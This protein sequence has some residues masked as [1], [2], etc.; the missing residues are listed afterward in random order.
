MKVVGVN[1]EGVFV[2]LP[3]DLAVLQSSAGL[4]Q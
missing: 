1:T 2:C 3:S 4:Q